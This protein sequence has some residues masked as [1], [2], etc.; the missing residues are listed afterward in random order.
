MK[1]FNNINTIEELKNAYKKLVM[2]LH[3]DL[4][5]DKDTTTQFQDMQNEYEKLFNEVKNLHKTQNG[6]IYTKATDEDINEFRDLLNIVIKYTDCTIDIIGNW[7]WICGETKS[8]KEDLKELGFKWAKNKCAWYYHKETYV[9]K[10]KKNYSMQ[11][12]QNMFKT[13]RVESVK[14]LTKLQA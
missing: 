9:K 4:N 3:P 8:H 1:Y 13:V 11:E 12:L 5:K 2:Q 6:E 14:E 10:S 7:I